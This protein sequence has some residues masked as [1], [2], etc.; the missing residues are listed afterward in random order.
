MS[1]RIPLEVTGNG[2]NERIAMSEL[3]EAAPNRG[4]DVRF[5]TRD[6]VAEARES[7]KHGENV[8]EIVARLKVSLAPV[9]KRFKLCRYEVER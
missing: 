6:L 8:L 3:H 9:A 1:R 5:I 2:I 4:S 7:G